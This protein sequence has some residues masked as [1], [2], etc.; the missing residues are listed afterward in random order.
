VEGPHSVLHPDIYVFLKVPLR[1]ACPA[2]YHVSKNMCE[3]SASQCD[4]L[5]SDSSVGT[6]TDS[7]W[8]GPSVDQSRWEQVFPQSHMPPLGP[9]QSQMGTVCLHGGERVRR[10]TLTTLS[11]LVTWLKEE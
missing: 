5:G 8:S 9:T 7:L 11:N 10:V 4:N 6:A 1:D 2:H 3:N